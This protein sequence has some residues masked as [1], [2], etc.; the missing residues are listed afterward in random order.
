MILQI[1]TNNDEAI[2]GA[3]AVPLNKD[4]I[5]NMMEVPTNGC[6]EILLGESLSKLQFSD[7]NQIFSLVSSK[8][9]KGGVMKLSFVSIRLL[10]LGLIREDLLETKFNEIVYSK[11]CLFS[12]GYFESMVK[13]LGLKIES[14][15]IS[16]AMY[17][18][19][20]SR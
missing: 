9:R 8:L 14:C 7:V 3:K 16:G 17:D 6:E 13:A 19:T 4:F 18:V 1:I 11:G 20:I 10:A 15:S 12:F 5:Q 2:E